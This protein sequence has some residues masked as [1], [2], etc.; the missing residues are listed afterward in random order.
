[1]NEQKQQYISILDKMGSRLAALEFCNGF[2]FYFAAA[3]VSC[4]VSVIF[5]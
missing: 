2:H 1:M 5:W 4:P 3:A